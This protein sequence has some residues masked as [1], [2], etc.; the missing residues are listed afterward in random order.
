MYESRA[1][2]P[3]AAPSRGEPSGSATPE[4]DICSFDAN[5]AASG[6]AGDARRSHLVLANDL[7]QS[8]LTIASA[9]GQPQTPT[10]VENWR[11]LVREHN[12]AQG[13][14]DAAVV[15][16]EYSD[17]QC[18]FCKKYSDETR[19]NIAAKYGENVRMV[20]KHY[21]LEQIHPQAMTAAI[22]AQCARRQGKFWE[23]HERLFG[24]PNALDVA[25]V[26]GIGEA[27]NLS[28]GFTECVINQET[29]AEVEQDIRDA[30]EI[31][32]RGT[33]TFIV[34]GDFLVGN[35][36]MSVFEAA[37]KKV[38]LAAD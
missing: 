25:S 34:N 38:G 20:F 18:P 27:L 5:R 19:R 11:T 8:L 30:N 1:I 22:A 9:G 7:K 6:D 13:S 31:G 33:P 10:R 12:A 15:V 14:E 3:P 17:F 4:S 32:V 21:P 26:V 16:I 36:A 29:K 24:Q 28:V 35:Q 23:V 37:F 2:A